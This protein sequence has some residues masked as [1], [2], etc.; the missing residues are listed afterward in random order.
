MDRER[1]IEKWEREAA[2]DKPL[3]EALF[4]LQD[5][6][7]SVSTH[8]KPE[9]GNQQTRNKQ[10]QENAN[11]IQE[12]KRRE[13]RSQQFLD[14]FESLETEIAKDHDQEV[15]CHHQNLISKK[16]NFADFIAIL[17]EIKLKQEKI[18]DEFVSC[19]SNRSSFEDRFYYQKLKLKEK[20]TQLTELK[21][22][23]TVYNNL[24]KI[25]KLFNSPG[26]KVCE[27]KLFVYYMDLLDA[28]I[29]YITSHRYA[30]DAELYLMR[31][32]S[33]RSRGYTLIK[34]YFNLKLRDIGEYLNTKPEGKPS[35]E[36][37]GYAQDYLQGKYLQASNTI[38]PLIEEL[39][40]RLEN[41][42]EETS[43][44]LSAIY[45]VYFNTRK[46]MVKDYTHFEMDRLRKEQT[47]VIDTLQSWCS[48]VLD[49]CNE[50]YM[51]YSWFFK[52][53]ELS[54]P[55]LIT[56]LE[57]LASCLYDHSRPIIISEHEVKT[58][59]EF[60]S[61]LQSFGWMSNVDTQSNYPPENELSA[62]ENLFEFNPTY[63]I[64]YSVIDRLLKDALNRLV[65]RAQSSISAH[66]RNYSLTASE[67]EDI[68]E[69]FASTPVSSSPPSY[70]YPPVSTCKSLLATLSACLTEDLYNDLANECVIACKH[71]ITEKASKIIS[72]K[73]DSESR[74]N[75]AFNFVRYNVDILN[76]LGC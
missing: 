44:V 22:G 6:D 40:K 60:C 73:L 61:V 74:N 65:F 29:D 10:V 32:Q 42:L 67:L 36:E 43:N 5:L 55:S 63:S 17:Q 37:H 66:I 64:F 35:H 16:R 12:N 30:R 19:K 25:M 2:L 1:R 51:V 21:E 58:L 11:S 53:I 13:Q 8:A 14:W 4:A 28:G 52:P 38:R 48:F 7:R 57:F 45:S 20:E 41:N 9:Q 62:P 18:R 76:A 50:E 68:R 49:A 33:C 27:N 23:L 54:K 24:E 26:D 31:Y 34:M 59:S 70:V 69:D 47:N 71:N 3:Q 15:Q 39:E 72:E 56:H 75:V 46:Q